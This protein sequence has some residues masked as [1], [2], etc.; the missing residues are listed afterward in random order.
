MSVQLKTCQVFFSSISVPNS[1]MLSHP[2][3]S[4]PPADGVWGGKVV[5]K[6]VVTLGVSLVQVVR[7]YAS[8][9]CMAQFQIVKHTP[10]FKSRIYP[11]AI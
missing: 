7:R 10:L 5:F 9:V 11:F 2:T 8:P 6:D 1:R 4:R 3:V